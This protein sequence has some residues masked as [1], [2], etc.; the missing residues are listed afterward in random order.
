MNN[1]A[2]NNH[3]SCVKFLLEHGADHD[4]ENCNG[5]TALTYAKDACAALLRDWKNRTEKDQVSFS[6]CISD[7]LMEEIYDFQH[8]ERITFI[9]NPVGGAV[10]A[11][12]REPFPALVHSTELRNAF[13][14]HVKRGG[15]R[16]EEE[17]FIPEE[18]VLLAKIKMRGG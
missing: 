15:E 10:E 14:E 5:R 16:T 9:R 7:R 12:T 3:L 6:R 4:Q 18:R 2:Y 11:V 1:A 8:L 13:N 17:V